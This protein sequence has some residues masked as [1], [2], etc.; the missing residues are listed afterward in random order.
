MRKNPK[1]KRPE[2]EKATEWYLHEVCECVQTCRA[3]RTKW[4]RQDLFASDVI[5]KRLDGMMVFAQAT[6]GSNE[7]VRTRRRKL[8]DIP[9]SSFDIVLLLQLVHTENPANARSKLW[10]FRVHR[11][12]TVNL[13]WHVDE[14][15]FPVPKTWFKSI[16][17]CDPHH[18]KQ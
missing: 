1:S 10:F 2:S 11:L 4:Q 5:G 3:I 12:D 9:W 14:E 17:N 7:A 16:K 13:I 8:E 15:A 18:I 6:A